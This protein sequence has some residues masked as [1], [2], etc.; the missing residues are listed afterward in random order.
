MKK[1]RRRKTVMR[2]LALVF[3]LMLLLSSVYAFSQDQAVA[4]VFKDG[5]FWQF[6][7]VSKGFA[8]STIGLDGIYELA[9]SQEKVNIFEVT[10]R[11]KIELNLHRDPE[12][13]LSL[14]GLSKDRSDLKFPFSVGQKW[15][16]EYKFQTAGSSTSQN[17]S[18]GVSVV[19]VEQVN[20]PAGSFR[21]FKLSAEANWL[22]RG[23]RSQGGSKTVYFYSTETKSIIKNSYEE[24]EGAIRTI[25]LV[26]FGSVPK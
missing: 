2:K 7:V 24:R 4:P 13:L 1:P 15:D 17:R 21:A 25:E 16:Y 6:K 18:V 5:D 9:Y 10:D 8:S 26:K 14:L 19:S 11:Q 22:R 3:S 23:A 12:L 20:T